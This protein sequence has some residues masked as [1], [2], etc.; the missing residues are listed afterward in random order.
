MKRE[1][2]LD[3]LIDRLVSGTGVGAPVDSG[4]VSRDEAASIAMLERMFS[5]FAAVR[6]ELQDVPVAAR[7]QVAGE[8]VGAFRLRDC[9]GIGGMGEVWLAERCD[10]IVEQC[11]AIKFVRDTGLRWAGQ[12]ERERRLLARL[13]HPYIAR[14]L[15]AGL[16]A[17]ERPYL[18][19]EYVE[20]EPID[21]WCDSRSACLQTRVQLMLKVCEGVEHAHRQLV[22]HRD[23]KPAN[24]LVDTNG[25]PRLLDFGIATLLDASGIAQAQ[26]E[27]PTLTLA[28][29]A[30]EQFEGRPVSTTTDV[31]A[32]GLVLY[33]LLAG[34]LPAPRCSGSLLDL[35]RSARSDAPPRASDTLRARLEQD[36]WPIAASALAGDCD[37]ILAKALRSEPDARYGSVAEFAAD[38]RRFLESRP[39]RARPPTRGYR[40]RR[41]VD[42]HRVGVLASSLGLVLLACG[43]GITVWQAGVARA[44]AIRADAE[45]RRAN[46]VADFVTGLIRE[47]NPMSRDAA[48]A[49]SAHELV[50]HGVLRARAELA[51]EPL[52]RASMLGVLGEAMTGLGDLEQGKALIE[53]ARAVVTGDSSEAARLDAAIGTIAMRQGRETEGAAVLGAALERLWLGSAE[54]RAEAARLEVARASALLSIGK[55]A[56]ALAAVGKARTFLREAFGPDHLRVLDADANA[57]YVLGQLR[58]DD[59][60]AALATDVAARIER[61]AGA[62]SAWLI[63]PLLTRAWV[64]KRGDHLD[65]AMPLFERALALAIE[66]FGER[67]D[68]ISGTYVGIAY[69][70]QEAGRLE[71]ALQALDRA[72]KALPADAASERYRLLSAK[73]EVLIDLG[74]NDEAER[75]LRE[76]LRLHRASAG[77]DNGYVQFSQSVWGRA[78]NALGQ[79]VQALEVQLQAL[80]RSESVFG[81]NAYRNTYILRHLAETYEASGEAKKAVQAIRRALDIA[82][83]TYASTHP[84]VMQYH[85]TLAEALHRAGEEEAALAEAGIVLTQ[86]AG[87]PEL[88]LHCARAALAKAKV[89]AARGLRAEAVAL[90]RQGIEYLDRGEI[91]S[92]ATRRALL[93]LAS[94]VTTSRMP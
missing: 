41:F 10:G 66:H 92:A 60:A 16:D 91:G 35:V 93:A 71:Q 52:L 38:L 19:M 27:Q 45:S 5:A 54:D 58:R 6:D 47:Q 64:E 89:L 48:K 55:P 76:A 83:L 8:Q 30:P 72:E 51:D 67:H 88:N 7:R 11:V 44:H 24:I 81:V 53:E 77:N 42:R 90:A 18:V 34:E 79:H 70:H 20:G 74:R 80:Q 82:S 50:V 68:V 13:A 75:V 3:D 87:H 25:T 84:V 31:H 15:D 21:R 32:L 4:G 39:V 23:L 78:L 14:F 73:G 12:L 59:E 17:R 85:P 43:L 22:V 61:V 29:A 40:L 1:Q 63:D 26:S 57:A 37:A 94:A 56:E 2:S 28:Y 86:C 46:R 49:R 65:T 62:H 9:L 69:T 36:G 33:R